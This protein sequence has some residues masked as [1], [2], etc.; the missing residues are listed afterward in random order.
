MKTILRFFSFT[1]TLLILVTVLFNITNTIT[2]E[3]N[4]FSFKA[5]VG[6][7]I[8]LS[9]IASSLATLL[10][11][12]SF[13]KQNKSKLKKQ[14]ENEKLNYELESEKVKQLEA[15]IKTLEEALKIATKK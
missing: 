5:N 2:L 11:S 4:F 6:F 1:L 14:I 9:A 12:L 10:F 8:F 3:S 7:L 13:G 15:K